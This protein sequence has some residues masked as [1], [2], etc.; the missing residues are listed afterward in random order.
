ME[1]AEKVC[2]GVRV[3][4][5]LAPL[6]LGGVGPQLLPAVLQARTQSLQN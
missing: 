3:Q 1:Q 2:G 5:R 4:T 6:E